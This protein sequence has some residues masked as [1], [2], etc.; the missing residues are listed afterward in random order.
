MSELSEPSGYRGGEDAAVVSLAPDTMGGIVRQHGDM[1]C[2][3]DRSR[4]E[5]ESGIG[6]A[7]QL[8]SDGN[9]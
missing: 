7:G 8:L 6:S 3:A 1:R 5:P 4:S 2:I 9:P